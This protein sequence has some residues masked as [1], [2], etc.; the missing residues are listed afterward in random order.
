MSATGPPPTTAPTPL[1]AASTTRA[2]RGGPSRGRL[3]ALLPRAPL[4]PSPTIGRGELGALALLALGL[5]LVTSWPLVLHLGSHISPDLGD[6]VRTVWQVAWLGHALIHDPTGIWSTNAFWPLG[7]SLAFSDSLLGYAPLAIVGGGATAALVR[8]NVLYILAWTLAFASPY[9]L[10][11]ELGLRRAG[12]IVAGAAFAYAPFRAAQAGHLHVISSGGVGLA[13]FLLLRGYRRGSAWLVASGWLVAAWQLSL[14]FTLGLQFSYLLAFLALVA[15]WH[16]WRLGRRLSDRRLVAITIVGVGLMGVVA[17]VQA[18]EYLRVSHDFPTARRSVALV[19]RYSAGLSAFVA[20][21]PQNRV[22]GAATAGIR[23]GLS[24]QNESVLFPGAS[25]LLLALAGLGAGLYPRWLR[26][27]LAGLAGA[28][29]ILALGFGLTAGGWPYRLLY[30]YFPGFDGIRT[31]GRIIM[32]TSLA[33]ALLAGAGTQWLVGAA[34]RSRWAQGSRRWGAAVPGV[35]GALLLFIVV[36]EGAGNLPHP[37]V[38]PVPRAEFQAPTGRVQLDLPSDPASDRVYQYWST[39][40]FR[41]IADGNS[42]FDIP[43]QDDLRGAMH[44]FPDAASVQKLR[45]LGILTVVLHTDLPPLPALHFAIPEPPDPAQAAR[46]SVAGL[47]LTRARI[48]S[49]VVYRLKPVAHGSG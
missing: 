31:P 10:A 28:C 42:T 16:W 23:G 17:G 19:E 47:P 25:I 15:L 21:P 40:G 48:G 24:S 33:L 45:S 38:P 7:H 5:A 14:G 46:K 32:V 18:H 22:W 9:L 20:A 36:F 8:Y 49:I 29:G 27:G 1:P 13:L 26:L 43:S 34:G 6:P 12:A 11:R 3:A 30:D 2:A 35:L 39:D 41:P 4:A 44:D 37:R